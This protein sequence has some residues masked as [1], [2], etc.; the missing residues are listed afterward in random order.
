MTTSTPTTHTDALAQS[1]PEVRASVASEQV[2]NQQMQADLLSSELDA[3]RSIITTTREAALSELTAQ[4]Q[5]FKTAAEE[6][7][8]MTADQLQIKNAQ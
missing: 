6:Y 5:G 7:E 2:T 4:R 3:L 1:V 8:Q